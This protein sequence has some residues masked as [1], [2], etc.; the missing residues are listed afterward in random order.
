M[1]TWTIICRVG[2]GDA[3][4]PDVPAESPR[5]LV[6]IDQQG[7][8]GEVVGG[9]LTQI[10]EHTSRPVP[11]TVADLVNLA[12]TVYAA[13]LRIA[14]KYGD[15]RWTRDLT[16]HLPV[17]DTAAWKRA[18]PTLVKML[19]YL[20][21][22]QW[23]VELRQRPTA[24][25]GAPAAPGEQPSAVSLFSGGLDSFIGAIDL[26]Q[27]NGR[28]ALVSHYGPGVTAKIQRMVFGELE[29]V[30]K[31]R[32][33][34]LRF[35]VHPPLGEDHQGEPTMR[36]RSLLFLA[37]GTAVA[38]TYGSA[39]PLVVPENGLVSLNVPLTG[40]RL[41]SLSTRTTHPHFI[42]LYRRV[43]SKLGLTTPIELPYRFHTKGEMLAQAK[44]QDLVQNVAKLTMSCAHPE[45]GRHQQAAPSL[46][47]GYCVPCIIRRAAME[48]AGVPDA[49]Y[50]VDVRTSPPAADSKTG[51]DL[52]AFLMALERY[53]DTPRQATRFHVLDAGPLPE[54]EAT[55]YADVYIRG[56]E[57]LQRF[58]VSQGATG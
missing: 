25:D 17:S 21:G 15:D 52:R 10:A 45:A 8:P 49:P 36:S 11:P 42:A 3:Y 26:A 4:A 30:C 48:A 57:E 34:H 29:K 28:I 46:H 43:L 5:L 27:G 7:V 1:S 55:R 56:M 33:E 18:R 13:D 32:L 20:T 2:A 19:E 58:L 40:T 44:N 37:L 54:G 9:L 14:R 47:C 16:I 6:P 38:A 24:T 41:S 51:R 35:W 39:V 50:R 31:G 53:S 23:Q 22:D 12:V